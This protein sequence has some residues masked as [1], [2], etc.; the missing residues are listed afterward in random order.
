MIRWAW[1][2][3]E[4]SWVMRTT[5]LPWRWMS[6]SMASTSRPVRE[7]KAPVGSSAR[8]TDGRPTRARAMD[9]RCCWPPESSIGLCRHLFPS[10]T[11][12]KA[13]RARS[14]R[15]PFGTPAYISGTSTFSTKFSLGSRLYCWKMKPKSSLRISAS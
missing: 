3:M 14:R 5:V 9:T 12:S 7:S 8:M 13:A 15:S 4:L 11:C 2:A 1:T 10:P 6:W